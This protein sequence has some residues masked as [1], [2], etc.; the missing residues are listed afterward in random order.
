ME[1]VL[2]LYSGGK[3]S[4]L[5]A[6]MLAEKNYKVYLVHYDNGMS[7]ATDNVAHGAKRLINRYGVNDKFEK[8]IEYIGVRRSSAIFRSFIKDMYNMKPDEIAAEYGQLNMGQFNCLSCR[9]AMYVVSIILCKQLGIRYVADGARQSQLFAIEQTPMLDL[10][11]E[12]FAKEGIRF[13]TPLKDLTDDFEEKNMLLARGIIP[14]ANES[15]CLMGMP[16]RDGKV[17][18]ECLAACVNVYKKLLLPKIPKLIALYDKLD[19]T[20][21]MM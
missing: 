5:T 6:A 21:K 10:F 9:L 7:L 13:L 8:R 12:L 2:V 17:D 15:Q 14:K 19:F 3:D 16:L 1:K 11:T 20:E 18:E 4:L